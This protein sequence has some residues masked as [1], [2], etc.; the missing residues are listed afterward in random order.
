MGM[1]SR[2]LTITSHRRILTHP[3][4]S[5]SS[6]AASV[7]PPAVEGLGDGRVTSVILPATTESELPTHGCQRPLARIELEQACPE[8]VEVPLSW[9]DGDGVCAICEEPLCQAGQNVKRVAQGHSPLRQL[10]C[11]HTFH[12]ACIDPWLLV[13]DRSCPTCRAIVQ[14]SEP[15]RG[16]LPAGADAWDQV[17]GRRRDDLPSALQCETTECR[18]LEESAGHPGDEEWGLLPHA[19]PSA[20]IGGAM[21]KNMTFIACGMYAL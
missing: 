12:S 9:Q 6:C 7:A 15:P 10:P 4:G 21:A 20:A 8:L 2:T 16:E 11:A 19:R 3:M 5:A 18:V 13:C 14:P 1:W 17:L